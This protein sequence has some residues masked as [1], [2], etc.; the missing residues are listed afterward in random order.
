MYTEWRRLNR[1]GLRRP[2]EAR[3]PLAG[4]CD[5]LT[6]TSLNPTAKAGSAQTKTWESASS[7]PKTSSP[8]LSAAP[9]PPLPTSASPLPPGNPEHQPP[10]RFK[11]FSP[12]LSS[13][14]A[15]EHT[16]ASSHDAAHANRR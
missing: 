14:N 4:I 13:E 15:D 16:L 7:A 10:A 3:R 1:G 6:P 8:R 5:N 9:A 11:P 12:I 2:Q